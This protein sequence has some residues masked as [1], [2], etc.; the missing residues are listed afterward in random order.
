MKLR[1]AKILPSDSVLSPHV[2]KV[3]EQQQASHAPLN[4]AASFR[5]AGDKLTKEGPAALYIAG[6]N[7]NSGEDEEQGEKKPKRSE[8]LEDAE[9]AME[10]I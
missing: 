3:I 1:A 4:A 9:D 10:G 7:A 5:D 6:S 2:R 8:F